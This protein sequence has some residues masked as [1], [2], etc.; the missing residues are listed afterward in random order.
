MYLRSTLPKPLN[1]KPF[2]KPRDL[3]LARGLRLCAR[4]V[5]CGGLPNSD[6]VAPPRVGVGLGFKV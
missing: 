5:R 1:P 4:A 2:L 3:L 6:L